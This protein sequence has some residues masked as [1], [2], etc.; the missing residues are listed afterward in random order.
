MSGSGAWWNFSTT[1]ASIWSEGKITFQLGWGGTAGEA[2]T[3]AIFTQAASSTFVF[4]TLDET[5]PS[6]F[7]TGAASS[8]GGTQTENV[9]NDTNTGLQVAVP[10]E[11]DSSL[12][13]GAI[14][15]Q[16]NI[17]S[18]SYENLGSEHAITTGEV[19][20]TVYLSVDDSD[21]TGITG[22]AQGSTIGIRAVITDAAGN[23]TNGS[24]S[25]NALVIDT[26]A[27]S[28]PTANVSS[29]THS[30][31]VALTLSSSGSDS[32]RYTTDGTTPTCST[33]T[34]FS[35]IVNISQTTT[36]RAIGCDDE[37][38]ASGVSTFEY[39]IS[40]SSGGGGGGG[41]NQTATPPT[42]VTPTT[43]APS[44]PADGQLLTLVNQLKNLISLFE[45]LG[46]TVTPETKSILDAFPSVSTG[47]FTRDLQV[48]STG[49]DVKVLQQWLN[50]NGYQ[51]A[52][53][54]PGSP[55]NE[56]TYFGVATQA[57][58]AKFQA[59]NGIT[60]SAGYLGPKTRAAIQAM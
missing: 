60:P 14:Q 12:A 24:A 22:Y 46:G 33:G 48:G 51:V 36:V 23:S 58:L 57:A 40:S 3:T 42:P 31:G 9:W 38:N 7:T 30:G 25:A 20:S 43:P 6:S 35:T 59:A 56:T 11:N 49:D 17:D 47:S 41:S 1:S 55:G 34:L 4:V 45:S 19:D 10:V 39:S 21:V 32:I 27:P 53:S 16:A 8:T 50:A 26:N 28:A 54:G 13:Y 44:V 15:L 2:T 5:A 37:G 18:G 52:A 29:G